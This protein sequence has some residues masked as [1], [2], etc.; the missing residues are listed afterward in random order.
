MYRAENTLHLSYKCIQLMLYREIIV[1][2]SDIHTKCIN[3]MCGQNVGFLSVKPG[4]AYSNQ[5]AFKG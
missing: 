5:W 2:C 3:T 1:F 4:D